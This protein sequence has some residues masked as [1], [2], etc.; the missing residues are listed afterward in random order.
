MFALEIIEHLFDTESFLEEIY[1]VLKPNGI[2]ILS[3]PNIT[4]LG[5]RLRCL[6]GKRPPVIECT[7]RGN[8][9]GHIRAFDKSD[10]KELVS[11]AGFK[12]IKIIGREFLLPE[13]LKSIF[14]YKP[15][16]KMNYFLCKKLPQFSAGFIIFARKPKS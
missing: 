5:C 2:L 7:S 15:V 4:G 3:T 10:I 14:P 1:R 16:K 11:E 6:F 13:V 9:S 12:E 8:V